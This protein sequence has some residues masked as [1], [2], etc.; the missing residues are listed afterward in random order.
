[1]PNPIT[2]TTTVVRAAVRHRWASTI[3]GAAFALLGVVTLLVEL[4]R[5]WLLGHA[6]HAAP[7][8]IGC[9]FGFIGFFILSPKRAVEGAQVVV[10]S[11]VSVIGVLRG[12]RRAT[13]PKVV[14]A[15]PNDT[16]EKS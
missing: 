13:D 5:Y 3:S 1:M 15:D 16:E 9:L 8:C 12:G 14:V 6:I 7:V 4:G 10:G 11:T 2:T